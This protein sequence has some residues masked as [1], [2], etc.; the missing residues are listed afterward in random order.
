M[1]WT[2]ST[3]SAVTSKEEVMSIIVITAALAVAAV[4]GTVVE[5]SRDG[6]HRVAKH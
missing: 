4:A 6:Y 2:Q 5:V 1:E 3:A